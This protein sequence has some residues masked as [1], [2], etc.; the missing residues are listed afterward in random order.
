MTDLLFIALMAGF[1]LLSLG[2][3]RLANY[4]MESEE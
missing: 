2:F 1:G 3:I 4:L